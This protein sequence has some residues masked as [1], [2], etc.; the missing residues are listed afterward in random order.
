M[1]YRICKGC[2][3]K[4]EIIQ[5]FYHNDS[6]IIKQS[7]HDFDYDA[8]ILKSNKNGIFKNPLDTRSG[9]ATVS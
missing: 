7:A 6:S 3:F 5:Y 8:M 9:V 4:E 2:D 1:F